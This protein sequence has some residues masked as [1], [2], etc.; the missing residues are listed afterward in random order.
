MADP[1]DI[2]NA[3]GYESAQNNF[4]AVTKSVQ[5]FATEMQRAS[6]ETMESASQLMEH[7]RGAKTVEDIV[8]IQ[9]N[10]MQHSFSQYTDFTRRMSEL[11]VSVPMEMAKNSKS[12][13]QQGSDAM[14]RAGEQMGEKMQQAGEQFN[15]HN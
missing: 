1:S 13:F 5:S 6:K 7:L 15:H 9:T 14:K 11:M 12:A 10:F 2:R 8:S 3:P 4:S